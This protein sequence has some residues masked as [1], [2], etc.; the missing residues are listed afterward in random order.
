MTVFAVHTHNTDV[1]ISQ[2]KINAFFVCMYVLETNGKDDCYS[3]Q[4]KKIATI[5]LHSEK[6]IL[7]THTERFCKLTGRI[8]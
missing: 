1:K 5:S 7:L 2:V 4:T 8:Y 3:W 6:P